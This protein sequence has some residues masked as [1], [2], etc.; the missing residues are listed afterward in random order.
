[1]QEPRSLYGDVLCSL[2]ECDMFVIVNAGTS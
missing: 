2:D 1:M